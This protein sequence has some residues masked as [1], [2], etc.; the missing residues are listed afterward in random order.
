M[1]ET[2]SKEIKETTTED[3]PEVPET[4]TP[5]EKPEEAILFPE[6]SL[7]EYTV[8]PWT[9]G[10]LKKINPHLESIFDALD[11]KNIQLSLDNVGE[12]LRELYFAALPSVISILSISLNVEEDDLEDVEV[13]DAIRLIFA[14][15]KQNEE[16]IKNVS[17]LLQLAGTEKPKG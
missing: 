5:E 6:L 2:E 4:P 16:S 13:S 12:Y 11:K 15:F 14:V 8:K 1:S 9:L 10:K 17:S 3:T 7:G